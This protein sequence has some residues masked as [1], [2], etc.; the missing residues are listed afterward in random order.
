MGSLLSGGSYSDD[1]AADCATT[2]SRGSEICCRV[3]RDHVGRDS[4]LGNRLFVERRDLEIPDGCSLARHADALR[5]L[6]EHSHALLTLGDQRGLWQSLFKTLADDPDNEYAMIDAT[7]RPSASAAQRPGRVR[8]KGVNQ[9]I[10]PFAAP[11]GLT[12]QKSI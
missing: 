8:R 2:S 10:E 6:E 4:E 11:G 9:A 7:T 3:V 1:Y 12:H 5:S